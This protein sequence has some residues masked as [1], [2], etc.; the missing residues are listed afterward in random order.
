MIYSHHECLT[1]SLAFCR[2]SPC[3]F[4]IPLSKYVKAVYHTRISVGM[5]FRMLFETEESSVRRYVKP[6]VISHYLFFG[7]YF[8]FYPPYLDFFSSS[9]DMSLDAFC[10]R[11][12]ACALSIY[13]HLNFS[14]FLQIHG[15]NYRNKWS[16]SCSLAELTLAFCKGRSWSKYFSGFFYGPFY[17]CFIPLFTCIPLKFYMHPFSWP[18]LLLYI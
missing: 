17:L 5:R 9:V 8:G 16:W 7:H 3:E 12:C 15:D 11:L 10:I 6:L 13:V 18:I 1:L 2:A 14:S 4:V